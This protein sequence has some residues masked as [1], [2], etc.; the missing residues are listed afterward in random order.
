MVLL[1]RTLRVD[2]EAQ[3]LA[4][5]RAMTAEHFAFLLGYSPHEPF[6]A[7]VGRLERQREGRDVPAGWVPASYFVAEVA[8]LIVGRVS[9]RHELTPLL[10]RVSGHIGFGVL[11]TQ[12]RRGYATVMLRQALERAAS[13]GLARVLVT[14]DESNVGS[15]RVIE[16]CGGVYEDTY[17]GEDAP[18]GVRRYWINTAPNAAESAS[19]L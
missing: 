7:F 13:L 1:L 16:R 18:Q 15:R 19:S 12:R 10:H 14:C 8:G 6:A 4:G 11:P 2:D 17:R 5:H 3:V 9:L